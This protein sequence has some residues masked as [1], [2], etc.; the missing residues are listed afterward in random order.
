M[1]GSHHAILVTPAPYAGI[2]AAAAP[3]QRSL[4]V[5]GAFRVFRSSFFFF[6]SLLL[7]S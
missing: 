5:V 4:G 3:K 7:G 2:A 6:L 1:R